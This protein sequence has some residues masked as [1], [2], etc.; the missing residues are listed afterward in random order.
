MTTPSDFGIRSGMISK[1][2]RADEL[3]LPSFSDYCDILCSMDSDLVAC[4]R[5]NSAGAVQNS[6]RPW[7]PVAVGRVRKILRGENA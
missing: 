2:E 7:N 4:R 5:L 6:G 3:S 1:T